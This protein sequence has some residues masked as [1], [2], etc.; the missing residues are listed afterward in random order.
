[1]SLLSR[2][3]I[4]AGLIPVLAAVNVLHSA[5]N[6]DRLDGTTFKVI[7]VAL[8]VATV[9]CGIAEYLNA[10]AF[11]PLGLRPAF[12]A[13]SALVSAL[14][15]RKHGV[16]KFKFDITNPLSAA[17]AAASGLMALTGLRR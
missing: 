17:Y 8:T 14:I 10:A 4:T 1:M 2:V 12:I 11:T 6:R 7:N 13:L 15:Y 16:P 9:G 3:S 5:A